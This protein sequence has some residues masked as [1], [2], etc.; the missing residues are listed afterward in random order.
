PTD[1]TPDPQE[2]TRIVVQ[3]F[4]TGLSPGVYTATVTLQFNDGR[5]QSVKVTVIVSN[6]V[7]RTSSV[8]RPNRASRPAD[9]GGCT[10]EK[11]IPAVKTL[12]QTFA[13]SAGWPVS[14]AVEVTDN[15][16]GPLE[17]GSVI[18]SFSNGDPPVAL[19]ALKE[20]RWEGTWPTRAVSP[21]QVTL[22]VHAED[23]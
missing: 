8:S 19:Q 9:I 11:L 15:C 23:P 16:G 4:T 21:G 14:L 22:K 20:G 2:A 13:V 12:G 10:P 5:V 18:A 1:A 7:T 3:P 17:S 6:T